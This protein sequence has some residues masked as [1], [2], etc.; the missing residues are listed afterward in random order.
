MSFK[1]KTVVVTGASRG[2]GKAIALEFAKEGATVIGTATTEAGASSISNYLVEKNGKGIG[3]CLNVRDSLALEQFQKA[4]EREF[5]TPNILVNN[6]GITQDNLLLRM[7]DEQWQ[8]VIDTNLTGVFKVSK[9]FL[10]GMLRAKWGRIINIAS[11]V[12]S[13]GNP[14]QANYAAAK[15]GLIA[16]TKSL[17]QEVASRSITCNTIAPGFIETDMTNKLA[18][19]QKEVILSKIP[20]SRMGLAEEVAY[21]AAFLASVKA[22]YITGETIHINGGMYMP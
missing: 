22:S 1:D 10:K 8:N 20:M 5:G 16:F 18:D 9:L 11:I 13:T 17:A 2:I 6:A 12:A 19:D 15:A 7:S 3:Y 14:G 21:V 4:I